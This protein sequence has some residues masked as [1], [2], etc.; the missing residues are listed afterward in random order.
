MDRGLPFP[1]GSTYSDHALVTMTSTYA[2][3]LLGKVFSTT[4]SNGRELKLRC[5]RADANLTNIGGNC[6]EYTSGYT[7]TN[8]AG[9]SDTAGAVCSAVDDAYDST[10]DVSQ[11]DIFYV[12]ASGYCDLLPESDVDAGDPVTC[13]TNGNIK[14]AT[15]GQHIVGIAQESYSDE[16]TTVSVLITNDLNPSDP[17][18]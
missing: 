10:F 16:T 6:V 18:G 8:V 5:V 3:H 2:Q 7:G 1:R 14:Q 12:V 11:Y 13:Y 17:S 4:D 15:A 9:I